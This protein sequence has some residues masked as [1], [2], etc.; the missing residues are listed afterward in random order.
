LNPNCS[1]TARIEKNSQNGSSMSS[2]SRGALVVGL[3]V[4]TA[5]GA[6][7]GLLVAPRR[8]RE[9][10]Q[11]LKKVAAA[12][13]ELAEDLSDSLKLQTDRL[14]IAAGD[15]WLGTIDRLQQALA[16][17]V[18]ASQSVQDQLRSNESNP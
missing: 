12:V 4:G 17:G 15:N 8:G 7:A 11:V 5:A 9:T 14:S 3:I 10:C 18:A 16:A 13:P 1:T 6:V 2:N